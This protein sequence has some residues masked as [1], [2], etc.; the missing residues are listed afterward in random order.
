M[1]IIRIYFFCINSLLNL[2]KDESIKIYNSWIHWENN[3]INCLISILFQLLIFFI[4][5]LY[6][7]LSEYDILISN[8]DPIS[9]YF[10]YNWYKLILHSCISF[11]VLL[12]ILNKYCWYWTIFY[13]FTT[14]ACA[15]TLHGQ[16]CRPN[17]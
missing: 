3:V 7:F 11:F 6:L 14:R 8:L 10:L 5:L 12:Y 2:L 17:L 15:Q 16:T 13:I 4:C 9:I 1:D